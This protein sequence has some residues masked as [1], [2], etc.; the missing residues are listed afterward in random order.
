MLFDCRRILR[1]GFLFLDTIR[2]EMDVAIFIAGQETKHTSKRIIRR[3]TFLDI[4]P[5]GRCRHPFFPSF[6]LGYLERKK[7][8]AR[9][10]GFQNYLRLGFLF[11]K[12]FSF[13]LN[14]KVLRAKT[15]QIFLV[16][17]GHWAKTHTDSRS[18][19]VGPF[20]NIQLDK[21]FYS[22]IGKLRP[23]VWDCCC[24]IT[25]IK[26]W[27]QLWILSILVVPHSSFDF[28]CLFIY[29]FFCAWRCIQNME[30]NKGERERPGGGLPVTCW[31]ACHSYPWDIDWLPHR[32]E[33]NKNI[34]EGRVGSFPSIFFFRQ[35]ENSIFHVI[36]STLCYSQRERR[37]NSWWLQRFGEARS[38]H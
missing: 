10:T 25:T 20:E 6:V 8:S 32:V 30:N 1:L 24:C 23:C 19:F 4:F 12:F 14:L 13:F 27:K 7:D 28:F 29:F 37:P 26:E 15:C 38:M 21:N 17:F 36:S 31:S 16:Y 11:S 33:R 35:T 22:T 34:M 5:D 18:N 2:D 9:L 3:K